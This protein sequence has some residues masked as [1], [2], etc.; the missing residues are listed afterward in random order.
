MPRSGGGRPSVY[1]LANGDRV[2]SCT[3]ITKRFSSS[4][5]LVRWANQIGLEGK[6]M[7]EERDNAAG[8]GK[9]AH[10]MIEN[11]IHGRDYAADIRRADFS[12]DQWD[13]ALEAVGAFA[14]WREQVH[15]EVLLTEM[16]LVSEKHRFGGTLDIWARVRD[17]LTVIDL[18]TSGRVY[19]EMILQQAGYAI[20]LDE[21]GHGRAEQI[22]LLRLGKEHADFHFHAYPRSVVDLASRAFLQQRELY[23]TDKELQRLL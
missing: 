20:L 11:I 9:L 5:G 7:D 2:P 15:L 22:S 10:S 6:S 4:E 8:A 14:S 13:K 12:D 18:K 16:P 1:K 3:T 23:D 17:R 19:G 21:N